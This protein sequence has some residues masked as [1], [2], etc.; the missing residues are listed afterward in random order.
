MENLL[1]GICIVFLTLV[2]KGGGR[3]GGSDGVLLC[4]IRMAFLSGSDTFRKCLGTSGGGIDGF[5][6]PREGT[7]GTGELGSR[8]PAEL[9]ADWLNEKLLLLVFTARP[10]TVKTQNFYTLLVR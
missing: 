8:I 3:K 10:G 7:A 5:L 4:V 6:T 1:C 9:G 2:S